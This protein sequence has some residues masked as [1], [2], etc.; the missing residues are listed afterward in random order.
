M[1]DDNTLIGD[2]GMPADTVFVQYICPSCTWAPI[3][4]RAKALW[5]LFCGADILM[6]ELGER[7]RE[8]FKTQAPHV[9]VRSAMTDDPLAVFKSGFEAGRRGYDPRLC[10]YDKGTKEFGEWQRGQRIGTHYPH[11]QPDAT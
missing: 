1:T 5:C 2:L 9:V 10:P 3:V 7:T 6:T 8:E 4:P 11:L